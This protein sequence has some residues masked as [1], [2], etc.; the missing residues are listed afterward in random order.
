MDD[1][2][3]ELPRRSGVKL[4]EHLLY[5][6]SSLVSGCFH[7]RINIT[8]VASRNQPARHCP[9]MAVAMVE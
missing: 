1:E 4:R 7:T 9:V 5:L 8:S 6:L 2:W 3:D